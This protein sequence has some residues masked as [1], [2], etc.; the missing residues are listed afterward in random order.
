MTE[1]DAPHPVATAAHPHRG[2]RRV[3]LLVALLLTAVIVGAAAFSIGRLS[4]LVDPN[5]SSTSAEAG[6]ARD[7]Q[8][9]HNQGVELALI[10]RDGTDDEAVRRLAYDITVTQGQQSGQMYAWLVLW[11]LSQAGPEPSMTWMTRPAPTD[12]DAD[13]SHA[14]DTEHVAGEPMPGLATSEQIA[15]LTAA[16]GAQAEREFLT[17]MIAH[18]QGAVEMAEAV[19]D[20]SD[21]STVR[22]FANAVV[23]SQ[24]SEIDLMTGML[25]ARS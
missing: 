22:A 13:S 25:E 17:L 14:H 24:K 11:E 19:L 2:V 8:T 18:H 20:R 15:S 16:S 12:S 10:I 9:H 3:T 7:M 1:T 23:M 5:P 6:F 4:T 21:N